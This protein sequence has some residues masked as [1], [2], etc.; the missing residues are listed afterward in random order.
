MKRSPRKQPP[1]EETGKR[2]KI[3]SASSSAMSALTNLSPFCL[4]MRSFFA[5]VHSRLFIAAFC[6]RSVNPVKLTM[7]KNDVMVN[8]EEIQITTKI[9]KEESKP[10][11]GV[12]RRGRRDEI[13][14][15]EKLE[16]QA[17]KP[18]QTDDSP[19]LCCFRAAFA[20]CFLSSL[21][22][23]PSLPLGMS[24]APADRHRKILK[25]ETEKIVQLVRIT[26]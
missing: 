8:D 26:L 10:F 11:H 5:R 3:E 6:G 24:A 9:R 2:G 25:Q 19:R 4:R 14:S 21:T 22:S 13:A 20:I 23:S 12:N 18:L 16:R 15:F 1:Q 17:N 7:L